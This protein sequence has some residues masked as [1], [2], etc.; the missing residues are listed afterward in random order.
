MKFAWNNISPHS[1]VRRFTK[2]RFFV[3]DDMNL[4][5]DDVLWQEDDE[6]SS[7]SGW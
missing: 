6:N 7:S 1:V 5:G 2:C 4:T 3:S